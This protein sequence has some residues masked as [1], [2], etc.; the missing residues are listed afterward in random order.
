MA[1]TLYLPILELRPAEML[2][3][4]EL[5]NKDKD[6]LRPLFR[7]R[8][9]GVS[10]Q[11]FKSVER[12]VKAFGKRPCYLEVPEEEYI[13]PGKLRPV[14]AELR[15]LRLAAGG[16]KRW[17][18]FL[19]DEKH[20]H[21]IPSLQK[22]GAPADFYEQIEK[23]YSLGRGLLVRLEFPSVE[24]LSVV[25]EAISIRTDNGRDVVVVLDYGKQNAAYVGWEA[26]IRNLIQIVRQN[27]PEAKTAISASSFPSNFIDIKSQEIY[28][29]LL[30]DKVAKNLGPDVIYSDRGSARAEKQFG[31]GGLPAP[32]I[33]YPKKNEWFFFRQSV[34]LSSA[35]AGYQAQALNLMKSKHWDKGLKL[36]GCQM[37]ERTAS[38][39]SQGGIS[40]PNRSTAVRINLH[41]HRQIYFGDEESFFDTDEE[42]ID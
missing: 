35:F 11:L 15:E 18:D 10:S 27:C 33:D 21:F 3:L 42:W 34:A 5:P 25:T 29:R 16:Y 26:I 32:R 13:D 19:N 2:A 6:V 4:D 8:P 14:H 41:L 1:N 37:I 31:G 12:L 30:F 24:E 39:D 17:F 20:S 38:G 22:G 36:W 7:L 23:L 40:S 9:W 28:E